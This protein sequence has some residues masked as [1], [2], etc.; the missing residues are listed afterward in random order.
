MLYKVN[1]DLTHLLGH[2]LKAKRNGGDSNQTLVAD[3]ECCI[4][5]SINQSSTNQSINPQ[6]N[7]IQT[8]LTLPEE[9]FSVT[10]IIRRN[11]SKIRNCKIT[12]MMKCFIKNI[13]KAKML[14]NIH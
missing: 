2:G 10:M 5:R 11:K 3:I 1:Y 7:T 6:Y 9:G 4:N 13:K 12:I 8:L 14:I